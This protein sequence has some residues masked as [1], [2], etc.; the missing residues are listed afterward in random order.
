MLRKALPH[1]GRNPPFAQF[2]LWLISFVPVAPESWGLHRI[3]AGWL[4]W[5]RPAQWVQRIKKRLFGSRATNR[6][7]VLWTIT[8][9]GSSGGAGSSV[10]NKDISRALLGV[11]E[12]QE[13]A[14]DSSDQAIKAANFKY[15][16]S[17][18]PGT[19]TLWTMTQLHFF[20]SRKQWLDVIDLDL[21]YSSDGKTAVVKASSS[22]T[23]IAPASSP[24]AIVTSLLLCFVSFDDFGQNYNHLKTIKKHLEENNFAVEEHMVA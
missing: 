15:I 19:D 6:A 1:G 21:R 10:N 9:K 18:N 14:I 23:G 24:F 3:Q 5:L 16:S 7:D 17:T 11:N 8:Q 12:I 4:A 2:M 20:T 22:S 13:Q